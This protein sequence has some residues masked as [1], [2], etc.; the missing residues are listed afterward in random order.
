MRLSLKPYFIAFLCI[1]AAIALALSAIHSIKKLAFIHALAQTSTSPQLN[2][3]FVFYVEAGQRYQTTG[4]LYERPT[5]GETIA[6]RYYPMAPIFKFPPAFQL[7]IL[8]FINN[9]T[10]ETLKWLRLTMIIGY[11]S[12]CFMLMAK[13]STTMQQQKNSHTKI[14]LFLA[15]SGVIAL[16]NPAF[17][18]CILNTNYEIPIFLLLTISFFLLDKH[19]KLSA[20]IISYLA[21]TKIYPI[22]MASM[23]FMAPR[24]KP[25]TASFIAS[26]L[27]ILAFTL[28]AFGLQESLYYATRILPTLLSE[29]VAPMQFS[30]SFGSELFRFTQ[31]L[32]FSR[33]VFQA[34]RLTL[35]GISFYTLIKYRNTPQRVSFFALL[36]TL[37]LICMPNYWI[38]YWIFLFPAFCIAIQRVITRPQT[39]EAS[40]L[41]L[42][43]LVTIIE[44]QSW[45]HFHAPVWLNDTSRLDAIGSEINAIHQQGNASLAYWLF[46]RHYPI[47]T[48]LYLLEQLKFLVPIVLWIFVIRE[49]VR[50]AKHSTHDT[51]PTS[52]NPER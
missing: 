5:E 44:S 46:L 41:F 33:I 35:V 3:D 14:F 19:A 13:C 45:M 20:A 50:T 42:C 31:N 21:L 38:S 23:L 17:W 10:P 9:W 6:S 1:T 18:D 48:A 22:F 12:A 11:F 51:Q 7:Q 28:W 24:K 16:L 47:T 37:M 32:E 43:V 34:L 4:Q 40:L 39:T 2:T 49:I 27:L 8:P 52:S 36:I 30:L 15:F 29:K 25:F 26:A